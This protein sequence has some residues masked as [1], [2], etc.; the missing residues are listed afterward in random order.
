MSKIQKAL[1]LN[2][3]IVRLL[4]AHQNS[5]GVSFTRIMT[6]AVLAYL[7]KDMNGPDVYWL[8]LAT[9][10]DRGQL[11][12]ADIPLRALDDILDNLQRTLANI[13]EQFDRDDPQVYR[14]REHYQLQLRQYGEARDEF[15]RR[16]EGAPTRIAVSIDALS[17][18][19]YRG[20]SLDPEW[21]AEE[22]RN[23]P[24]PDRTDPE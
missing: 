11:P 24:V 1:M 13:N 2:E 15:Q 3:D 9:A 20:M 22:R 8:R 12:V 18:S 21:Q 10:V 16:M 4:D 7:Y 6:A 5:T 19:P 14:L 23:N 17:Q